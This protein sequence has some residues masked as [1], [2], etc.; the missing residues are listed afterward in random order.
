MTPRF[1]YALGAFYNGLIQFLNLAP[2]LLPIIVGGIVLMAF[3]FYRNISV[4][5]A[6]SMVRFS[7][8]WLPPVLAVVFFHLWVF[9]KRL[10]FL[11]SQKKVLLEIRVPQNVDKSP[12]AMEIVLSALHQTV[13]E[14]VWWDRVMIGKMRTY[15]S[16]EI[17]SIE[18]N[19]K[20]FIWTRVSMRK[21]VETQIYSQY[22][23]A[24]IHEA[25]DY[26]THIPYA[27]R[28]SH[29]TLF[30]TEWTLIKPDPYP[31]KTYVDY[32]TNKDVFEEKKVDPITPLLEWMGSLGQGEQA[33]FQVLV[34]ANKGPKDPTT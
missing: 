19:V 6:F 21:F 13:G 31:I 14:S 18:G 28:D 8:L 2:F 15:F 10:S 3:P 1:H 9:Y 24:E 33:W 11:E 4:S 25:E 30:G 27:T 20:F 5:L 12:L 7:P 34:R 16:L 17:V 22:P 29:W 26:I 23:S 32:E